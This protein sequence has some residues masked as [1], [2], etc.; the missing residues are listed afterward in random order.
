VII[1]RETEI[2]LPDRGEFGLRTFG[3]VDHTEMEVCHLATRSSVVINMTTSQALGT[4]IAEP[5]GVDVLKEIIASIRRLTFACKYE[6]TRVH[7]GEPVRPIRAMEFVLPGSDEYNWVWFP[8]GRLMICHIET[9]SSILVTTPPVP[10]IEEVRREAGS[11][12]GAAI[13]DDILRAV[14]ASQISPPQSGDAGLR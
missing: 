14:Q 13:L 11:S 9:N 4:T 1:S 6:I 12:K 3:S 10:A 7:G 5:E 8:P 2:T